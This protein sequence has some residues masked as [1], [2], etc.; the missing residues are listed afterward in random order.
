M[1][2]DPIHPQAGVVD[3]LPR[4]T[5]QASLIQALFFEVEL[6]LLFDQQV[7]DL[8]LRDRDPDVLEKFF[9]LGFTGVDGIVQY[10]R[11]GFDPRPKLPLIA[12]WQLGQIGLLLTRR[13]KLLF[14]K[15]DIVRR[16][17]NILHD[18]VLVPFELGIQRQLSRINFDHFFPVNFDLT[19][20][21]SFLPPL[22]LVALPLRR[23][24]RLGRAGWLFVRLDRGLTLLTLEPVDLIALLLV[25]FAQLLILAR[26]F[27][28][29]VEQPPNGLAGPSDVFNSVQVKFFQHPSL[30][31]YE[32]SRCSQHSR[33]APV[34]PGLSVLKFETLYHLSKFVIRSFLINTL[35]GCLFGKSS[36]RPS[37]PGFLRR[38]P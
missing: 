24:I 37:Y 28:D 1:L 15:T 34:C 5:V 8:S 27:F 17:L 38:Y 33:N 14:P 2:I 25:L 19:H 30:A 21:A 4:A 29:Q 18:N 36:L 22:G 6:L 9:D 26:Q 20:F 12:R 35:M 11:R 32:H 7:G 23:I 3:V 31:S 10:Y 16:N 13:I